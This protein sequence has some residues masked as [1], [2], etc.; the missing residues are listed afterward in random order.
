MIATAALAEPKRLVLLPRAEH[1][2]AG[3]LEPMQSALAAWLT[4]TPK[5]QL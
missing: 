2:F 1:F 4:G 5:E 3:Q